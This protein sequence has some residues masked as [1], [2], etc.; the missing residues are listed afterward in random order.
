MDGDGGPRRRADVGIVDGRIAGIG[1]DLNFGLTHHTK[2]ARTFQHY[3][4]D[5]AHHKRR[6]ARLL[7]L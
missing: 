5:A 1:T 2:R 6:L 3:L 7:N 4:G